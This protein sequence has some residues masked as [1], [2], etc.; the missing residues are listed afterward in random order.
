MGDLPPW[1]PAVQGQIWNPA[2]MRDAGSDKGSAAVPDTG[3]TMPSPQLPSL[4]SK[5]CISIFP[6]AFFTSCRRNAPLLLPISYLLPLILTENP[7]CSFYT[8]PAA[9]S[10]WTQGWSG[11]GHSVH[12]APRRHA[13]LSPCCA[14]LFLASSSFSLNV[15]WHLCAG[16]PQIRQGPKDSRKQG[17]A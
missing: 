4:L 12:E 16:S 7:W 5:L 11:G 17:H 2:G 14:G 6:A 3:G 13:F 15:L 9:R 10:W 8:Q 1:S